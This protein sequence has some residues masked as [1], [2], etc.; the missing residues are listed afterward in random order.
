MRNLI[1]A[2]KRYDIAEL[3]AIATNPAQ[4]S[5][6][7][8][9]L[10][11][12]VK[13]SCGDLLQSDAYKRA[14]F[15]D[16]KASLQAGYM[17]RANSNGSVDVMLKELKPFIN[18]LNPSL[19]SKFELL[20][21]IYQQTQMKEGELAATDEEQNYNQVLREFTQCIQ[22]F[23]I[24]HAINE[25]GGYV[26]AISANIE[27]LENV[28]G[29]DL[30]LSNLLLL[31]LLS[32]YSKQLNENPNNDVLNE[33]NDVLIRIKSHS[34]VINPDVDILIYLVHAKDAIQ[35]EIL[36]KN[37]F[38]EGM[39]PKQQKEVNDLYD[40]YSGNYRK[41]LKEFLCCYAPLE[42]IPD[43]LN[44]KWCL[45][46][47]PFSE[48]NL[49]EQGQPTEKEVFEAD[50]FQFLIKNAYKIYH[51]QMSLRVDHLV[52][53]KTHKITQ[54]KLESF[55]TKD[56]YKKEYIKQ[57]NLE[58]HSDKQSYHSPYRQFASNLDLLAHLKKMDEEY[59]RDFNA[60]ISGAKKEARSKLKN[61][62]NDAAKQTMLSFIS[63][64]RNYI[65]TATWKTGYF[66]GEPVIINGKKKKL[67]K[68]VYAIY[69][70]CKNIDV[71]ASVENI[72]KAFN[73]IM[74]IGQKADQKQS[75]SSLNKR[76]EHTR[77]FYMFFRQAA[78]GKAQYNE[79]KVKNRPRI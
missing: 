51:T 58:I 19:L 49:Q 32:R 79:D 74:N 1:N 60:V 29:G 48:A 39:S 67:P 41:F 44:Q 50:L 65:E 24:D 43:Y 77:L 31:K 72:Q 22:T 23:C 54:D 68:N 12:L 76:D 21:N 9:E 25:Y 45:P 70:L 47:N 46:V 53:E 28:G 2:M 15:I 38:P 7:I 17:L 66:G 27:S 10:K 30:S 78:E 52:M 18:D 5:D 35:K 42:K 3:Q 13:K 73:E 37:F 59:R 71:N 8:A 26:K 36:L 62:I 64:I 4:Y 69:N 61:E 6:Q 56:E 14:S 57:N 55:P 33:L 34:T 75:H 11:S 20:A 16:L 40:K 63:F